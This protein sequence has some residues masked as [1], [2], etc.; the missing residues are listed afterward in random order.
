MIFFQ[1]KNKK[2][3]PHARS[4]C[5]EASQKKKESNFNMCVIGFLSML[6]F[7]QVKVVIVQVQVVGGMVGISLDI[8]V[9]LG[10]GNGSL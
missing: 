2:A 8:L 1:A 6:G 5:D 4:A 3:S 10:T 9:S 7:V